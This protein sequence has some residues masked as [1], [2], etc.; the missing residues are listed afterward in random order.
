ME[1]KTKIIIVLCVLLYLGLIFVTKTAERRRQE[2]IE[3]IYAQG[4]DLRQ[5][6]IKNIKELLE[7][8]K[9]L[10]DHPME[11]N[12]FKQNDEYGF[13]DMPWDVSFEQVQKRVPYSLLDDSSG[14]QI[15]AGY[16]NYVSE[17][18]YKLYGQFA[19][20]NFAFHEDQLKM[21]QLDFATSKKP[22]A[23]FDSAVEL[24]IDICGEESECIKDEMTG[25][26]TYKWHAETTMLQVSYYDS[27]VVIGVGL[28][29]AFETVK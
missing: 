9:H 21:V 5:E 26:I 2:E 16:E 29:E 8:N 24:L 27:C 12:M 3:Q 10:L 18:R 13:G 7:D 28:K 1:K 17:D 14:V 4:G 11:L 23:L 22:Q 15:P 6:Q 19:F 25:G 20:A